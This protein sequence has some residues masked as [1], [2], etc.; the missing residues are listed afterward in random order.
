MKVAEL[1]YVKQTLWRYRY[2]WKIY[3]SGCLRNTVWSDD[4]VTVS[5]LVW[6]RAFVNGGEKLKFSQPQT[7]QKHYTIVQHLFRV[8]N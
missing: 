5:M 4:V 8:E 1:V 3:Y 2:S 7:V 6:S